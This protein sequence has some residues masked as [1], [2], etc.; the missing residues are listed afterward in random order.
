MDA[1]GSPDPPPATTAPAG[2]SGRRQPQDDTRQALRTVAGATALTGDPLLL[3]GV[4][5]TLPLQPA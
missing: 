4:L 5:L 2:R 1:H 3:L